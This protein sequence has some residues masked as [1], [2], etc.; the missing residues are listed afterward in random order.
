M[1]ILQMVRRFEGRR[2]QTRRDI[3]L[4]G[5]TPREGLSEETAFKG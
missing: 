4:Y 3:F 2:N 1:S 5:G